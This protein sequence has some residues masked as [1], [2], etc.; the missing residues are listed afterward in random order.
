MTQAK[1]EP[2]ETEI[3]L[4]GRQK[5]HNDARDSAAKNHL[6]PERE[7][8]STAK[9]KSGQTKA[10]PLDRGIELGD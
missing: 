8:A 4:A 10:G 3:S 6:H 7:E 5:P 1:I 2:G 9:K